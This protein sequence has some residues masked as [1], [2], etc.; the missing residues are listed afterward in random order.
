[1]SGIPAIKFGDICREVKTSTKNPVADGYERYVGLEH[2]NTGSLN[3]ERWGSIVDDKPTFTRVFKKGQLLIGRRRAY[4]KKAGV[5]GFDGICS[6]DIIVVEANLGNKFGRLLPYIVRSD[7]FWAWA[8]KTSAGGLSPRTK[9]KDLAEFYFCDLDEGL[10]SVLE[11][12]LDSLELALSASQSTENSLSKLCDS[13]VN[14]A[15]RFGLRHEPLKKSALGMTPESWSVLPFKE[16]FAIDSRNGL[17][18]PQSDYGSGYK[19]V[20]MGEMFRGRIVDDHGIEN[21]VDVS[22]SEFSSFALDSGDLLFA[23][24]SLVKEGAG[25]CCIYKGRELCS[26]FESSIIRV[27]V[28]LERINPDY[29][30]YFFRSR[31]GRWIMERIIQTVAASGITGTDLKNMLVPVPSKSEQDEIVNL[32]NEITLLNSVAANARSRRNN[33]LRGLVSQLVNTVEV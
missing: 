25:V 14:S 24:R 30:S 1:M 4:L 31:F 8:V 13:I 33:L 23:R 32:L 16:V 5:A 17:Y 29:Y 20:H 11:K 10:V 12:A 3:I 6:G 21:S 18:K 15:T 27:R 19:M 7:L 22:E 2:L 28:D 26:T 9:F